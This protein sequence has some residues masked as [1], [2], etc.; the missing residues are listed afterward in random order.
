M[1]AEFMPDLLSKRDAVIFLVDCD[2]LLFA[3]QANDDNS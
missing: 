1:D 2:K 3:K